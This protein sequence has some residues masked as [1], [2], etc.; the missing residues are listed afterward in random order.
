[1]A[2]DFTPENPLEAALVS[3]ASDPAARPA[4]YRAL[5]DAQLFFLT[6]P[7]PRPDE[8]STRPPGSKLSLVQW[9]GP[10][11][12]Y[13]PLFT[14]RA[15]LDQ[16]ASQIGGAYGFVALSG[17]AAFGLLAQRP[18]GAMLNPGL[19]YG[20]EL[21]PSEIARLATGKLAGAEPTVLEQ[22]TE[23]MLGQPAT[24]PTALMEA[25][26]R[27][28]ARHPAVAA[29]H[30]AQIYDPS[31]AD[32]PH[33][34]IGVLAADFEAIVE[35]AALVARDVVAGAYPVDFVPLGTNDV[36]GV[37]TYLLRDTKPFYERDPSLTPDRPRS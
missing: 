21:S 13:I 12:D 15:R 6:P 24:P 27:L 20:K 31:S 36:E 5:L 16:I 17:K 25:L 34:I 10:E 32:P 30:L 18:M 1:V 28:F 23:V 3:A 26:S 33:P 4:F 2:D 7:G 29:A 22:D 35:E 11:G 8:R 37:H 9:K 14:S 19:R